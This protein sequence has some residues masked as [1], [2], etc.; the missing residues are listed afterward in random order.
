MK[1][2]KQHLTEAKVRE[3]QKIVIKLTDIKV[4]KEELLWAIEDFEKEKYAM[5]FV[6]MDVVYYPDI[7]KF[8][9]LDG[10]HRLVEY[11]FREKKDA[12]VNVHTVAKVY[13]RYE[14]GFRDPS[15]MVV[16]NKDKQWVTDKKKL[17]QWKSNK[18]YK[19]L[20]RFR[21][22]EELNYIKRIYMESGQDMTI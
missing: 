4:D 13:D 2:F 3:G 14:M 10:H 7:K 19:G 22:E 6:Q 15:A 20:E 1:T 21:K 9:L 12:E 5:T 16:F 18:K 11:I 17:F 8:A